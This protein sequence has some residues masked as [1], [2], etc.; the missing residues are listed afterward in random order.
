MF[1]L[2]VQLN[3]YQETVLVYFLGRVYLPSLGPRPH[4][5]PPFIVRWS[6]PDNAC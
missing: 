2:R 3:P 6:V 5:P 4:V 1:I